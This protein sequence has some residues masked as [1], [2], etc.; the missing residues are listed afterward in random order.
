MERS[1]KP[2]VIGVGAVLLFFAYAWFPLMT[3]GIWNAPDETAAAFF[4]GQIPL[5][6]GAYNVEAPYAELGGLVHPRSMFVAG[7]DLLPGMWLGLPWLLTLFGLF[8]NGSVVA[9]ELLIAAAAVATVFAWKGIVAKLFDHHGVGWTAA[10]LL[11]VH[12]GWWYFTARG[13]HPNVLFTALLIFGV[14]A[15][16]VASPKLVPKHTM[17]WRDLMLFLGG[18]SFGFALFVRTNE[19]M[20]VVPLLFAVAWYRRKQPFKEHLLAVLGVLVPIGLML[21]TNLS[22]YGHVLRT[23]YTTASDPVPVEV[24][25]Q[26]ESVGFTNPVLQQLFPFGVH[27]M[28]VVRNVTDFHVVFFALWTAFSVFGLFLLGLQWVYMRPE[29]KRMFARVLVGAGLV[30]LYLFLVY[31]SWNLSDNPDPNAVTIGTSYIRY[32]LPVS[33]VMTA[34]AAFAVIHGAARRSTDTMRQVVIGIWLVAF[35]FTGYVQTLY[36]KDEGLLFVKE[37][38]DLFRSQQE[39]VLDLTGPKDL[40][41]VDRSDKILFPHRSVRYALRSETTYANL[42][43]MMD[44]TELQDARLYYLGVT[45]PEDDLTHLR[46][47]R[48]DPVGL[49]IRHIQEIDLLTLYQITRSDD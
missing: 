6:G 18:L 16:F 7:G 45:L 37:N 12:P 32:W 1:W 31:G 46:E 24:S 39:R 40:I 34:F 29:R 27:E 23:G 38:L 49:D 20:W 36:G 3:G 26:I 28:N 35:G 17:L 42:P 21:L 13:L 19:A 10:F 30:S 22:V 14:Y 11:A 33:V 5:L 9:L 4:V 41:I 48:L 47:V 8:T 43:A 15:W 44:A 2:W 25:E